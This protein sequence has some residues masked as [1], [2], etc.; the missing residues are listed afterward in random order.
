[1]RKK[2]LFALA[3]ACA[4]TEDAGKS[5]DLKKA[6]LDYEID[7]TYTPTD[8]LNLFDETQ[9]VT[10]IISK[11]RRI[12]TPSAK[13]N[14]NNIVNAGVIVGRT[15]AVAAKTALLA[16]TDISGLIK[17]NIGNQGALKELYH[18][19]NL[20]PS[21]LTNWA[22]IGAGKFQS[23]TTSQIANDWAEK[24]E[25]LLFT[26]DGGVN[27]P[28]SL[29]VRCLANLASTEAEE[30]SGKKVRNVDINDTDAPTIASKIE[31]V[32]QKA[33]ERNW[34]NSVIFI[35][36]REYQKYVNE[37]IASSGA[38]GLL[39]IMADPM[40]FKKYKDA[41]LVPTPNLPANNLIMTRYK[42]ICWCI[43][44]A[45]LS[46]TTEI[47]NIPRAII[48]SLF[49]EWDFDFTTYDRVVY[50]YDQT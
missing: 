24:L 37:V 13:Y 20:T 43:A 23:G 22:R 10:D 2:G 18:L 33:P 45:G 1:M 34:P 12:D 49:S 25:K 42:D 16:G 3:K 50:G 32:Y 44:T 9:K 6:G 30:D 47:Q 28:S 35:N 19:F 8:S 48:Y 26:G 7:G 38:T 4:D 27:E 21:D 46:N 36:S 39:A 11:I 17:S 40:R 14:L 15:G 41:T 31:L 29:V 5:F